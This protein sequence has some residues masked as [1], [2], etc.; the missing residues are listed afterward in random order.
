VPNI[1]DSAYPRLKNNPTTKELREVYTPNPHEQAFARDRTRQPTQRVGL[2]LLLK[3]FQRLGYFPRYRDI[4]SAIIRHISSCAG[5][6]DVHGDLEVIDSK[7]ARAR[8]TTAILEYL[9]VTAY[10]LAA[11]EVITKTCLQAARTRDD[12][13]DLINTA[14]EELVRQRFE[15]PAY[16]T[17]LRLA[18]TAR[19][20]VNQG[21][22]ASLCGA[23]DGAAKE[24]LLAVLQKPKGA[25]ST[26]DVGF[27]KQR[28]QSA[29]Y[30]SD[31]WDLI[32]DSTGSEIFVTRINTPASITSSTPGEDVPCQRST[33]QY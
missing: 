20:E 18:R 11:R 9:A 24:R 13:P 33:R 8:H 31:I 16:D 28:L 7:V 22:Q 26:W 10:G 4:P 29:W 17:L 6:E 12:L 27:D 21:Y 5:F 23:L 19:S 25:R 32:V 15:L 30:M 14:I 1:S 3:T 2:L